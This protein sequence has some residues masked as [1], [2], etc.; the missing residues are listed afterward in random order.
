MYLGSYTLYMVFP[1]FFCSN[2]A[3]SELLPMKVERY[4]RA[5]YDAYATLVSLYRDLWQSKGVDIGK[6]M[7]LKVVQK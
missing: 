1:W 7:Y 3:D 2:L 6:Y 4:S 5:I